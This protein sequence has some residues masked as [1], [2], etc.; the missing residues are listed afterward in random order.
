[1]NCS[2]HLEI[3][4]LI[5]ANE[6]PIGHNLSWTAYSFNLCF[7]CKLKKIGMRQLSLLIW[8]QSENGV[9][10]PLPFSLL[11]SPPFIFY[12]SIYL[13]FRDMVLLSSLEWCLNSPSFCFHLQSQWANI[14][15]LKSHS[16][17]W[18]HLNLSNRHSPWNV[19]I[20]CAS[21]LIFSS[22][23]PDYLQVVTNY[24]LTSQTT[25]HFQLIGF[26]FIDWVVRM[27]IEMESSRDNFQEGV[28]V[29]R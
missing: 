28:L 23:C 15:D 26:W 27:L 14:T 6:I 2:F 29:S 18:R 21:H 8:N 1:M 11:P 7:F 25:L 3:L 17:L 13:F 4:L 22:T 10:S 16:W 24:K 5:L 12:L 20:A 19:L 9:L